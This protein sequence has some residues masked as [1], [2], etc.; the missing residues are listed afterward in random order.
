MTREQL[1]TAAEHVR[2]AAQAATDTNARDRL[3]RQAD[4]FERHA[5]AERGPDHGRLA[6]HESILGEIATEEGGEVSEEID[7]ALD[8]VH[9]YRETL[10]GV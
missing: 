5:E 4:E 9:T 3:S 1:E 6:R 8:H 2:A 7:A 10:P